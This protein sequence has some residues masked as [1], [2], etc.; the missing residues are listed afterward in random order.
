MYRYRAS[1]L[2]Y[3]TKYPGAQLAVGP[4]DLCYFLIERV[5]ETARK[6]PAEAFRAAL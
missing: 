3:G 2:P 1:F 4:A 5:E 6:S